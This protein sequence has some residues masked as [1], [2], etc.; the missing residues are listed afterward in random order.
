[1]P[2]RDALAAR[3]GDLIAFDEPMSRHTSW[4]VGGPAAVFFQPDS[5]AVLADFLRTIGG[6]VPVHWVGLGSNLL[7]RD[8]GVDGVVITTKKLPATLER[9]GDHGIVAA[10]GVPCTVLARQAVRWRLGP[11]EFF[12]GIPGSVGGALTM[13]AGAHGHETWDVVADVRVIDRSGSIV[14][15]GRDRFEIAYRSVRGL[16]Q[17]WFLSA[18]FEFDPA[19]VPSRDRMQALQARRRDTQPLGLPSCGSVFRNPP[20]DHAARLI[21]AAGLKGYRE[22]GAQVSE[23][24]ANF[25]INAA[26]ASAADIEHLIAHVAATVRARHGVELQHEVRFLGEHHDA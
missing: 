2:G 3:F 11:S 1:M 17:G 21:E 9:H 24:H 6:D 10:A 15:R 13:N 4:R 19:Y 16:E 20:G 5:E 26:D 14:T 7:V 8:G 25:I 22:G 23:K 12:A 18:H